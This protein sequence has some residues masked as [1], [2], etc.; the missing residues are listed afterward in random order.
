[1][2]LY[3][4]PDRT[5]KPATVSLYILFVAALLIGFSKFFI[6]DMLSE[7]NSRQQEYRRQQDQLAAYEEQL[8]DYEDIQLKYNLYSATD[9][10]MAQVDRM[11]ILNLIDSKIRT[12]AT[13]ESVT[14]KEQQVIIEFSGVTLKQTA[15]IVSKLEESPI[16]ADITVDTASTADGNTDAVK[17]NILINLKK[18]EGGE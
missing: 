11:D 15:D 10:E 18:D 6:Y 14:V 3:Y 5:T 2:N 9:E 12:A 8:T 7:V 4:K 13:V 16:V 1:M 17:T